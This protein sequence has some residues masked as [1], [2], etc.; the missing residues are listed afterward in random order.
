MPDG[1]VFLGG[2][3]DEQNHASNCL[4]MPGY[5]E[6]SYSGEIY[7]PPYLFG[8]S[9]PY[10]DTAPTDIAFSTSTT[11]QTFSVTVVHELPPQKVVLLRPASVTHFFDSDQRY[12]ELS[13]SIVSGSG[14]G[15]W[16]LNVTSPTNDLGPDGWYM[17]F[18]LALTESQQGTPG[19]IA[20]SVAEFVKFR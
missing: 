3:D 17:L 18:V 8:G 11:S 5:L 13:F 9:R 12:I 6:A 10:I 4:L 14:P 19:I 20:P 2:G 7:S 16:T 15:A 1:R